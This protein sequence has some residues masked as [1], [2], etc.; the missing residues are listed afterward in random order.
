MPR[1]R[2]ISAICCFVIFDLLEVRTGRICLDFQA[3]ALAALVVVLTSNAIFSLYSLAPLGEAISAPLAQIFALDGMLIPPPLVMRFESPDA[4]SQ[5][6][7]H[8]AIGIASPCGP[9]RFGYL[10]ATI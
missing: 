2:L 10:P 5:T 3:S 4:Q 7:H 9:D 6:V 1:Q 8:R